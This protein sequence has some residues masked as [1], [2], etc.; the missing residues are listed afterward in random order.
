[1]SKLMKNNCYGCQSF[2]DKTGILIAALGTP[3]A[4]TARALRPYLKEFLSDRRVIEKNKLLWWLILNGIILRT[5]PKKSAALYRRIWTDEGSPL[6]LTTRQQSEKLKKTLAEHSVAVD[7]GMRYGSPSLPEAV[8]RLIAEGCTRILLFPMYP[9]YSAATIASTYD[10]VFP[11]LRNRRFVPTLRVVDPYFRHPAYISA[12]AEIINRF[13]KGRAAK[14]EKLLLSYHGVPEAYVQ[15]GDPYCCQCA[16][17][18]ALLTEHISLERD[19][20]VHAYQSRFGRDP[21]IT[22]FSDETI[23]RWGQEG[24]KD[25]AISCP[26][27]T[28][29]CLETI[30]EMGHEAA[31][32]FQRSG[33]KTLS[34]IPCL[35]DDP[36]WIEAMAKIAVGAMGDWAAETDS[37]CAVSCPSGIK[38]VG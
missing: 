19:D 15:K 38:A 8:E 7:F 28:A 13:L 30:D 12:Q 1:M 2:K 4:P 16:S 31:E 25:I 26:G 37:N 34:L 23:E 27:F 14:P 3:E 10:A 11:A 32:L 21:W 33:G 36:L 5:R 9:Q 22:P 20:I 18:T 24:I 29:D 35:N 6:L 17:T